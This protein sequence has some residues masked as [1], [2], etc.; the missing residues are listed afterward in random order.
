MKTSGG[1]AQS[2]HED[3]TQY[4][5]CS[6]AMLRTSTLFNFGNSESEMMKSCSV[7]C[8]CLNGFGLINVTGDVRKPHFWF[9]FTHRSRTIMMRLAG[10]LVFFHWDYDN[11]V[12]VLFWILN[13]LKKISLQITQVLHIFAF[14]FGYFTIMYNDSNDVMNEWMNIPDLYSARFKPMLVHRHFTNVQINPPG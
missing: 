2:G 12:S 13:T 10:E 11:L 9:C 1:W 4:L 8:D 7:Q 5:A 6:S 14:V 3:Q